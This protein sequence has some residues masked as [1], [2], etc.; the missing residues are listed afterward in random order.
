MEKSPAEKSLTTIKWILVGSLLVNAAFAGFVFSQVTNRFGFGFGG[1][2]RTF[3]REIVRMRPESSEQTRA[4]LAKVFASEKGDME[5]A[6][7]EWIEARRKT[8]QVLRVEPLDKA[9]LDTALADMRTKTVAAQEVYHRIVAQAAPELSAEERVVLARMLNAAP[10]RMN[11]MTGPGGGPGFRGNRMMP[12]G[13]M[14]G[15]PPEVMGPPPPP[16][17]PPP[18]E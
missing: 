7:R 12:P 11:D 6:M 18:K 13:E 8:V 2:P 17:E 15:E 14:P 10:N 16:K 1:G 4:V 5:K 9:A 3:T